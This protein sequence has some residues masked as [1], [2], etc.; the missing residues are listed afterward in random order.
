MCP[1]YFDPVLRKSVE[2]LL[3]P[4]IQQPGQYIGGE[5]GSVVKEPSGVKYRLALAFPDT[6]SIGMSHFGY[7]LLYSLMNREPDWACERVFTPYP[8][9]ERILRTNS[10]PLYTL[11]T[12]VPLDKCDV[13]G[14]SL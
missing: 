3:L 13:L 6:Y 2:S 10:L 5:L 9:F 4:E 11:E 14:F 7:Q 8:D 1:Y 12:F